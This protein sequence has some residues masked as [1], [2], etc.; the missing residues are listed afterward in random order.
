MYSLWN[1]TVGDSVELP[2]GTSLT[3]D[4]VWTY[5][6]RD[7]SV[8]YVYLD[9]HLANDKPRLSVK[10]TTARSH[11]LVISATVQNDNGLYNCYDGKGTRKVG[12]ILN[13]SG[14]LSE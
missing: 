6:T 14:M 7:P 2:C 11:S 10:A 9:G 1:V 4:I 5:D 3:P 8:Q 12:Y 13:T